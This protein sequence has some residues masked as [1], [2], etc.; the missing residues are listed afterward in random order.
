MK[1]MLERD[2]VMCTPV[3]GLTDWA[4]KAEG[5]PPALEMLVDG[6][7]EFKLGE[8]INIVAFYYPDHN[9]LYFVRRATPEEIISQKLDPLQFLKIS[10]Q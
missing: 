9:K 5:C 7:S 3:V 8:V 6:K 2:Q 4:K 1:V 10:N